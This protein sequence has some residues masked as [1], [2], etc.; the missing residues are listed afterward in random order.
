MRL[1]VEGIPPI[2]LVRSLSHPLLRPSGGL[3][4]TRFCRVRK[5]RPSAGCLSSWMASTPKRCL[6]A[7]YIDSVMEIRLSSCRTPIKDHSGVILL[8]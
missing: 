3:P 8:G 1:G 6:C 4:A 2:R 5:L 7:Q